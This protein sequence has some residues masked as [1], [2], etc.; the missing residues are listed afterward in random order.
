MSDTDRTHTLLDEFA[1]IHESAPADTTIEQH[2]LII[3]VLRAGI[4]EPDRTVG[5]VLDEWISHT[6]NAPANEDQATG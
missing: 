4:A 5:S 3:N 2:L 6:L 1:S